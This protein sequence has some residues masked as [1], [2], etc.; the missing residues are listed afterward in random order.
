MDKKIR[1]RVWVVR[2]ANGKPVNSIDTDM[3]F[4]NRHLAITNQSEMAQFAFGTLDNWQDF[5]KKVQRGDILIVGENFGSGSS[6]QQAVDCFI[7]L[8][9]TAIVGESFG[10]I[11]FRNVVKTGM[12]VFV[13]PNIAKSHLNNG[14]T[15]ELDTETGAITDITNGKPLPGAQPLT[16]VQRDII[17]AGG[18]FALAAKL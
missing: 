18:L 2:D 6:R 17:E 1:G 4:H 7:A 11:Y 12:P 13:A 5:P 10:A 9:V 3:I 8:G 15:I 14:D 16:S